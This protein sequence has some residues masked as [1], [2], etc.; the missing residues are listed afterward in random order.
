MIRISSWLRLTSNSL[1][2]FSDP[3]TRLPGM[4]TLGH[5]K[6]WCSHYAICMMT[7]SNGTIFRIT[8]PLCGEFTGSGEFPAQRPV[9]RSFDVFFDLCLNK[10]LGKQPWGWWFETPPWSLW[11]QCNGSII[12]EVLWLLPVGHSTWTTVIPTHYGLVTP[13]G[14]IHVSGSTLL[15]IMAW[16]LMAPMLT[17]HQ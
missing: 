8:G 10:R 13:Y 2:G 3:D 14:D 15:Q 7:S 5:S 1:K 11:R 4:K 6:Q 16:C 12:N 9:M 17:H